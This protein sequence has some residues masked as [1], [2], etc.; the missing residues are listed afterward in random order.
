[1]PDIMTHT[2]PV[3][4][5]VTTV[6]GLSRTLLRGDA[7][8]LGAALGL[9]LPTAPCTAVAGEKS[10]LWLGP[11]EW[12]LLSR[13][14]PDALPEDSADGVAFGI[15]HRQVAWEIEGTRAIDA[16]QTGC[17][18]DLST[19]GTD[20]CTRTVFG[21]AEIVLWRRGAGLF[22]VEAWRS[23]E[24]YVQGLLAEAIRFLPPTLNG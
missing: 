22:H 8:A 4:A 3:A 10:V 7:A 24:P 14:P 23:F 16:L 11:D 20:S 9:T 13:T 18:L 12:L 1:M 15:T 19:L 21:K 17:P 6:S 2:D 5:R